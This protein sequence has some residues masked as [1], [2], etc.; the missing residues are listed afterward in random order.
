MPAG[1]GL[2]SL[3]SASGRERIDRGAERRVVLAGILGA[4]GF[5]AA[6]LMTWLSGLASPAR[7]APLHLALAGAASVAIGALLPHFTVS[8][9]TARPAPARWRALALV[10]LAV[11]AVDAVAA[12]S[13]GAPA[14]AALGAAAFIAGVV[15]TALTAFVPARRGLGRRGGVVELG[16][17][18]GLIAVS[19]AVAAAM[20][21]LAGVSWVVDRWA[22]IKP[23]HAWLNLVGFVTVVVAATLIHLYPTVVGSRIRPRRAML[24]TVCGLWGGAAL[25]A[26]GYAFQSDA[27]ARMGALVALVG[28]TGAFVVGLDGRHARGRWTTDLAWHHLVIGHLSAAIAWL[29]VGIG[30]A[31]TAVLVSGAAPAGWSIDRLIGPLV[32]GCFLQVLI[33]AWSHLAPAVGPGDL[34]RHARQRRILG[35]WPMPRVTGL[36]VAVLLLS[37]GNLVQSAPMVAAGAAFVALGL[38]VA[39]G[40][41]VEMV[42][43]R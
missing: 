34:A 36:N 1:A 31:S 38:V 40:L 28:A 9:A 37:A 33:G 2:I 23:A 6:A 5:L 42:V 32:V 21:D 35:R 26:T 8:L 19:V 3:G 10:L 7:W 41:M 29:L 39:L 11:G 27:V 22:S 20:L 24:V 25:V 16:Y 4:A 43:R 17:G 15:L 14:I 12:V 30:V 18:L 13:A